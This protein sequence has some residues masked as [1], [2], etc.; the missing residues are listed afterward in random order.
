MASHEVLSALESLHKELEKLEPAIRHVEAAQAVTQIVKA[1]PQKHVELLNE[2]GEKDAQY[3]EELK[4]LFA[5][6]LN[7]ICQENEKLQQSTID[8]GEQ[9]KT[10]VEA[11]GRL[12]EGIQNF[13]E[14]VEKINFPERLDKVDANVAGIMAAVQTVQ[15]R[16]DAVERNVLDRIR[17]LHEFEKETRNQVNADLG[18]IVAAAKTQRAFTYITWA[19]IVFG[20]VVISFMARQ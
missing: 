8:I 14:R 10:E 17:D 5:E 4:R 11:L 3:K 12:K 20:I 16:F 6:E 1:I 9:V 18:H 13:H 15:S 7:A 2:I 19:L